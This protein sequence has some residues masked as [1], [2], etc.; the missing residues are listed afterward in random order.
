MVC[1]TG[2][3]ACIAC[4][5]CSPVRYLPTHCIRCP[6]VRACNDEM[7]SLCDLGL[8]AEEIEDLELVYTSILIG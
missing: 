3:N 6:F 1:T 7:E 8:S 5:E 4:K 2:L